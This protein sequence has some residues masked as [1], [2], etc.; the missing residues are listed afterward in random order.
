MCVV[1]NARYDDWLAPRRVALHFFLGI[2]NEVFL[3]RFFGKTPQYT[4][5]MEPVVIVRPSELRHSTQPQ[6]FDIAP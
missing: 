6:D 1:S 4:I 3:T 5:S 2:G